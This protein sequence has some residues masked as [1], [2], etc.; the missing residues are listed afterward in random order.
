MF[1]SCS[2]RRFI[3]ECTR[4]AL[5]GHGERGRGYRHYIS[6]G[7]VWSHQISRDLKK[8]HER[9]MPACQLYVLIPTVMY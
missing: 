1:Q 5:S 2:R 7:T 3:M 6:D 8:S 9:A 4:S